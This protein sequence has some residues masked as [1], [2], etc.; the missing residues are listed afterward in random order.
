MVF[1]KFR[2]FSKGRFEFF[3]PFF[4][5]IYDCFGENKAAFIIS[6]ITETS[7]RYNCS[8][9]SSSGV[10]SQSKEGPRILCASCHAGIALINGLRP[11]LLRDADIWEASSYPAVP[12]TRFCSSDGFRTGLKNGVFVQEPVNSSQDYARLQK[13]W[14]SVSMWHESFTDLWLMFSLCFIQGIKSL[15]PTLGN[16]HY[17]C[18]RSHWLQRAPPKYAAVLLNKV[19]WVSAL[20][21]QSSGERNCLLRSST[22]VGFSWGTILA[23]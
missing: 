1:L 7:W 19:D 21:R 4:L 23:L 20:P 10:V 13:V 18:F 9:S 11:A 15:L 6:V 12:S 14:S 8:C 17:Y 16:T 3:C 5:A 2:A 22:P